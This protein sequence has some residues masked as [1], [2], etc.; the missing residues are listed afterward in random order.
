MKKPIDYRA[1]GVDINAGD[2]LV[3]RIG[4]AVRSTY[5]PEVIGEVT[6]GEGPAQVALRG[7][8]FR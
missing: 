3:R 2:R 8:A 7:R 5:R 4:P 1:A 6:R